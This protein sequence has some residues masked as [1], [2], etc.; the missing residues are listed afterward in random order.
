MQV[1]ELRQ[2]LTSDADSDLC[3][4]LSRLTYVGFVSKD[5]SLIQIGTSLIII[6][7]RRF[8]KALLYQCALERFSS[9]PAFEFEAMPL[10]DLLAMALRSA[11]SGYQEEM[12]CKDDLVAMARRTLEV[13]AEMLS[14]YFSLGISDGCLHTLP[15]LLDGLKPRLGQIPLFL[16]RLASDVDWETEKPCFRG[17]CTVL[18]HFY[19]DSCS[20]TDLATIVFPAI[21][22]KL[23]VAASF[24]ESLAKLTST[25][26]LYKV[27]ERC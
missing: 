20:E 12:N 18:A 2:E 22:R 13:R 15:V 7:H 23:R 14:E 8:S 27:F 11:E 16:L 19:A 17:V 6:N 25:E 24:K 4:N 5:N 1:Q 26:E 9:F 21:R 3:Q 10:N